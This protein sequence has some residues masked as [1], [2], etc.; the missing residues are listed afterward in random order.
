MQ[1]NAIIWKDNLKKKVSKGH[2]S[3]CIVLKND[4]TFLFNGYH[5]TKAKHFAI[6]KK[7]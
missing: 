3:W 4:D 2:N 5:L 7:F 6:K 1:I